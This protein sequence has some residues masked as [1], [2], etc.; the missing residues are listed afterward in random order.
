MNNLLEWLQNVYADDCCNGSWEH[1]HGF[2]L[3]NIDNPGWDFRF[4]LRDSDL[5]EIPMQKISMQVDELNWYMCRIEKEEFIGT[6]GAK[7]LIDI[8]K[9]FRDWYI[10]A[11]AI[12][13]KR[14]ADNSE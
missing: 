9:V 3:S 13:D 11:S 6:G 10:K 2:S 14:T 8:L 7:N 12:A 4:D 5:S 1:E